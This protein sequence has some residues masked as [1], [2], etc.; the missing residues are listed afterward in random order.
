MDGLTKKEEIIN[1]EDVVDLLLPVACAQNKDQLDC[2]VSMLNNSEML[3]Q[4]NIIDLEQDVLRKASLDYYH[5]IYLDS[6]DFL[7]FMS[8][9]NQ[10]ENP[11]QILNKIIIGSKSQEESPTLKQKKLGQ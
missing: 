2:L 3:N 11:E 4:E 8:F 10:E 6:G 7:T 9:L 1:R 5:P